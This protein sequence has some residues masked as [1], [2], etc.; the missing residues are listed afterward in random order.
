MP[1]LPAAETFQQI[2]NTEW[3]AGEEMEYEYR[4]CI[5]SSARYWLDFY[6]SPDRQEIPAEPGRNALGSVPF[7]QNPD[8]D[9]SWFLHDLP[10]EFGDISP[11][12]GD[13]PEGT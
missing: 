13:S 9:S 5:A 1:G 3:S 8:Q 7:P 10:R 6:Y 2:V 12:D 11:F 4:L